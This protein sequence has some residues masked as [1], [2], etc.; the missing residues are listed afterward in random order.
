MC[1][2]EVD[3]SFF[4]FQYGDREVDIAMTKLFGANA[5]KFYSTY[6]ELWP[7]P[8]GWELRETIYN[9]YHVLNHYVLFGGSYQ[10]QAQRMIDKIMRV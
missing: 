8:R 4:H 10:T 9:L 6:N 2:Y 3:F 1:I 7:L 5:N